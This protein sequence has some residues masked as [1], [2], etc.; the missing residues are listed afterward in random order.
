M[1][2]GIRET[3]VDGKQESRDAMHALLLLGDVQARPS[4]EKKKGRRA[5]PS[6]PLAKRQPAI[7]MK[8]QAEGPA[9]SI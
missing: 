4:R 5:V 6:I 7:L 3:V 9:D 8:T 1:E 2:F